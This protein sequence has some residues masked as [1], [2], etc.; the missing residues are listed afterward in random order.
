MSLFISSTIV[1]NLSR[2]LNPVIPQIKSPKAAQTILILP[3]DEGFKATDPVLQANGVVE[4]PDANELTAL[5]PGSPLSSMRERV[6]AAL[7][8]TTLQPIKRV[9]EVRVLAKAS[10]S[11]Y[12]I[13]F[14]ILRSS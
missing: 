8:T 6:L 9:Y 7:A 10:L 12:K 13:L 11:T 2:S 14:L 3:V 5:T 4:H 1:Q